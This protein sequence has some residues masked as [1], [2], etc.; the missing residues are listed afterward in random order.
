[1]ASIGGYGAGVYRFLLIFPKAANPPE[2]EAL[3][4]GITSWFKTSA[5]C[6]AITRSVGSLMGP[7]AMAGEAGWVLEADFG[8]LE[9]A[10]SSIGAAGFRD[11]K[12]ATEALGSTI[13][14]FEFGKP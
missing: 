14:L 11:L 6:Q 13:F 4:E 10:L 9:E 12:S 3:I 2:A 1:L 5:G 8:S 7:A